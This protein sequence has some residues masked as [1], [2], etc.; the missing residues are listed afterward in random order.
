MLI[1]CTSLQACIAASVSG[2]AALMLLSVFGVAVV[3]LGYKLATKTVLEKWAM[4]ILKY[5]C[6]LSLMG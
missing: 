1:L 5:G 2:E 3:Y 4:S 6:A